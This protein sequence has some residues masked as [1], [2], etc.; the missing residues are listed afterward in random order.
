MTSYKTLLGLLW[1]VRHCGHRTKYIVKIDDSSVV[2]LARLTKILD[3]VQ[4]EE[5]IVCPSVMRGVRI[6]RHP[7]APLHGKWTVNESAWPAPTFMDHCFGWL[8]VTS[9]RVAAGLASVATILPKAVP[10]EGNILEDAL[11]T[12]YLR[13]HLPGVQVTCHIQTE[14][15]PLRAGSIQ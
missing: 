2:D 13:S 15:T 4:V 8:W 5:R 11:I 10:G 1:T 7:E 9:P 6:W 14:K 12:G 3:E